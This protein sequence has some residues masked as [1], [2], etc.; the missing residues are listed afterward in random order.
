MAATKFRESNMVKW[1][2][3]R[4]AHNGE[5]A[6]AWKSVTNATG[7]VYTVPAGKL[8]LLTYA[9]LQ[10]NGDAA[11]SGELYIRDLGDVLVWTILRVRCK[12]SVGAYPCVCSPFVYPIEIPAGYDVAVI[13]GASGLDVCGAIAGWIEA[14]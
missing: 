12:T 7:I 3:V 10:C 8:L 2:G 13:S 9:M 1:V 6:L 11:G 14:A 5:Q 4:P